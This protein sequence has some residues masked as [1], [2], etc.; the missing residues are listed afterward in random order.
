M[1][2]PRDSLCV[3]LLLGISLSLNLYQIHW[4]LPTGDRDWS[5]DSRLLRLKPLAY[6]KSLVYQE[7]WVFNIRLFHLMVLSLFYAPYVLYLYLTGG[8]AS[9]TGFYPYGL[10]DP[11]VSLM[12]FTLIARITSAVM[13]TGTVLVSYYT[14]KL[15]YG[16]RA[17]LISALLDCFLLCDHLLLAQRQRGRAATFLDFSRAL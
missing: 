5:P 9:P 8:M 16:W 4:G 12:V 7:P 13:G 1:K 2:K 17:G 3:W 10:K 14:V 6:A 15:L 11:E